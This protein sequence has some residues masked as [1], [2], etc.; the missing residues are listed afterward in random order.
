[1]T[2]VRVPQGLDEAGLRQQL[3]QRFNIEI[4]AGMGEL[5]EKFGELGPLGFS[6]CKEN[7]LLFLGALKKLL[8]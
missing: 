3:P 6:S 2:T 5:R 1:L 8:G 7:I 4:S